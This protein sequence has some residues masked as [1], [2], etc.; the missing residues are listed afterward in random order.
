MRRTWIFDL[1]NT[2]HNASPHIFPHINRSMREYIEYQLGLPETEANQLRQAYWERY[3]ATLL[4]LTRHHNI[5][6][7]HFLTET[8]R[9]TDLASMVVYDKPLRHLLKQLPGRKIIFSN[10]P[11]AYALAVLA[12]TGLRPLFD[13]VYTIEDVGYQPK[14]MRPAFLKLLKD[15]RLN[16]RQCIMVEDS[17]ANLLTAKK[18]GM[19]TVWIS[20]GTR[21]SPW[22]DV[23]ISSAQDLPRYVGRL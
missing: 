23:K 16:P 7:A 18:L 13:T 6:P 8:H 9:F 2:L 15:A 12:I 4:G 20:R 3:G 11:R 22:A 5:D 19:R 14:P 17:L 1:D 21:Q 10:G